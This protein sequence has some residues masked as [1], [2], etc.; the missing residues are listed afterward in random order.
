MQKQHVIVLAKFN[1]E[2]SKNNKMVRTFE[3]TFQ[4]RWGH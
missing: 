2:K 3:H 1:N 4:L